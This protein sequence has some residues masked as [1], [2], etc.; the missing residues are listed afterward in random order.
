M[1][2]IDVMNMVDVVN[3]HQAHLC[4]TATYSC[5]VY[6]LR[7][8]ELLQPSVAQMRWLVQSGVPCW[9]VRHM[10]YLNPHLQNTT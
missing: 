10:V 1:N 7:I 3:M 6:A 5:G 4:V 9:V 2:M 8:L